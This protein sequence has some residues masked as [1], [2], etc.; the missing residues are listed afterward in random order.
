[1]GPV[2]RKLLDTG[3][4]GAIGEQQQGDIVV[5][6]SSLHDHQEIGDDLSWPHTHLSLSLSVCVFVWV[7]VLSHGLV[8]LPA[9]EQIRGEGTVD[10]KRQ[11]ALPQ[12]LREWAMVVAEGGVLLRGEPT[13]EQEQEQR[14]RL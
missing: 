10:A 8:D 11:W 4:A 12:G 1:M 9:G 6:L 3:R 14:Q 13:Q 5:S 7:G 2:P